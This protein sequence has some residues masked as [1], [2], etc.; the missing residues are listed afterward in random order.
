MRTPHTAAVAAGIRNTTCDAPSR[1][2]TAGLPAS[3]SVRRRNMA[4]PSPR[5]RMKVVR[6]SSVFGCPATR[7]NDSSSQILTLRVACR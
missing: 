2:N 1:D 5:E 3:C 7:H 4:S 6:T